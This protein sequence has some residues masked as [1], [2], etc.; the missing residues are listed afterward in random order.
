ME[1]V[2][3]AVGVLAWSKRAYLVWT[4]ISRGKLKPCLC[5]T[6]YSMCAHSA[7]DTIRY[8][9]CHMY[10]YH[11]HT[12]TDLLLFLFLSPNVLSSISCAS[13]P[14]DHQNTHTKKK[15]TRTIHATRDERTE[16]EPT[17]QDEEI[18]PNKCS[19][20][21]P[22]VVWEPMLGRWALL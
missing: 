7:H 15:A 17:H 20:W 2:V 10:Q 14:S 13:Q 9:S 16:S 21:R 12:W 4:R 1:P 5:T 6:V 22:T 3:L 18:A 8:V 11:I 19:R